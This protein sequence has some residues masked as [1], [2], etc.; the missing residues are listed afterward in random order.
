MLKY[1]DYLNKKIL[2]AFDLDETIVFSD[3][4]E[5]KI[6]YLVEKN[7]EDIFIE[8]IE[9]L[10]IN[11]KDLNYENSRIYINDP[12]NEI[13]IPK[14]S[15][16]VR[17]KNR[18]YLIQPDEYLLTDDSLPNKRN[19]KILN[20]YNKSKNKCIITVRDIQ[21]KDKIINSIKKL[22]IELPNY[23][24][25]MYPYK[26]HSMKA[27]WK[28]DILKKLLKKH[29]FDKIYYFDDNNKLLKKMKSFLIDYPNIII[30]RV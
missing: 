23:G 17:K 4:I 6:K 24:I 16:W 25:Y 12:N 8:E 29:D 30:N 18:I 20:L 2:Y 15:S 9:K 28:S 3:K 13:N 1:E 26:Y 27:E 14:K 7:S 10:N 19:E 11:I 5:T 22:N 21:M